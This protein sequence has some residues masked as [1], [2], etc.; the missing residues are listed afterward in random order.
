MDIKT[1]YEYDGEDIIYMNITAFN[2]SNKDEKIII[3]I[4]RTS[5]ILNMP[6]DYLLS[7]VRFTLNNT[8]NPLFF[9]Y[10][11]KMNISITNNGIIYTEPITYINFNNTQLNILNGVYT[12]SSFAC[13]INEAL[14]KAFI[15][16]GIVGNSPYIIYDEINNKFI[17]IA[18]SIFLDIPPF[19]SNNKK[20]YM[21]NFL[22]SY[23]ANFFS[24]NN[25]SLTDELYYN[26]IFTDSQIKTTTKY[27]T[28]G[29]QNIQNWSNNALLNS[30]TNISVLSSN[31]PI[32][33]DVL[34][35]TSLIY[36]VSEN[37]TL[38][39]ISD[40]EINQGLPG[41]PR[42]VIQYQPSVYRFVDLQGTQPLNNINLQFYN[43][44]SEI[45]KYVPLYIFSYSSLTIKLM[46]KRKTCNY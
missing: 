40:Y 18:E 20:I 44:Y 41:E 21:N 17:I 36:A 1:K 6:K 19:T 38:K 23:F 2:N 45:G 24:L 4:N 42:N 29:Y 7:V 10:P 22:S 46:F 30:L 32:I 34:T 25:D 12:Y 39:C 16:S 43:Y 31:I 27:N 26:I 11:D 5:P 28:V 37:Q 15:R 35:N 14:K 3:N 13:M 8:L 9:L 33:G